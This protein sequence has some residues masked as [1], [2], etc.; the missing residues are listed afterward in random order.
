[1]QFAVGNQEC[2][3]F[4]CIF[5]PPFFSE[6]FFCAVKVLDRAIGFGFRLYFE[7]TT[8]G[9]QGGGGAVKKYAGMERKKT[10]ECTNK[11]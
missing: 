8:S 5:K 2:E 11:N 9:L 6:Y 7:E 3:K 1:M 4:C 10:C